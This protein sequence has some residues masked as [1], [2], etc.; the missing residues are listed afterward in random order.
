MIKKLAI[1]DLSSFIF[2]AFFGIRSL[3]APDGTPTNAVFGVYKMLFKLLREHQPTHI[4]LARDSKGKTF[5]HEIFEDYKANRGEPPED[6]IPQFELI[7]KLVEKMHLRFCMHKGVEA[8]DII[9]SAVTQWKDYFDEIFI[10]SSDKDLMQF[11]DDEKVFMVDT[12]KDKKMGSKE[13]V[14]KLGV[15]P[16]QVVDY[17]TMLGDTSDNIPGMRG[18]GK[19]KAAKLLTEYGTFENCIKQKDKFTGKVLVTAFKDYLEDGRLSKQLVKIKTDVHLGVTPSQTKYEFFPDDELIQYLK[20]DLGFKGASKQLEDL[21][22]DIQKSDNQDIKDVQKAFEY[23]LIDNQKNF[24]ATLDLLQRNHILSIHVHYENQLAF[25]SAI[26]FVSISIDG[27]QAYIFAFC[28]KGMNLSQDNLK[29]LLKTCMEKKDKEIIGSNLKRD[30][31]YLSLH[32]MSLK[33]RIFDNIVAHYILNPDQGHD[34]GR[35]CSIYL[36]YTPLTIDKK[37]LSLEQWDY[38]KVA[39]YMGERACCN[40]LL[41]KRLK[42]ELSLHELQDVYD[43]M[44]GPMISVLGDLEVAGILIDRD[45]FKELDRNFSH[46]LVQIEKQVK[47]ELENS[48]GEDTPP[49][50]LRSPKQVGKLLFED[51]K[52]P[53]IKKTKT[54]YSTDSSVLEALEGLQKSEIPG[55]ILKFREI[56]KL[57]STYVKALPELVNQKTLRLHTTFLLYGAATGR[58]YSVNPN[59]QNIPVRSSNGI[60]IRQGFVAPAD[61]YLLSADYSQVELRLLA[62]FSKDPTMVKAFRNNTD[63]HTQTASEILNIPIA[64]VQ[65]DQRSMAK[66]VNFGLIY[67]QSSFGLSQQLKISRKEA[68]EYIQ[69][70]FE[71]FGKIRCYLDELKQSAEEIGY[72]KTLFGRKR[73]LPDI[74]SQNR[75]I[76]SAAERVAVNSPIQGTAADIIKLAMIEIH[77]L[78]EKKGLRAKMLLQVHD[79]LIFEVPESELEQVKSLVKETMENIVSLEVPLKVDLG[80]GKNWLELK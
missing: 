61:H 12:M 58:L 27:N 16:D 26:S 43:N 54:G 36:D 31:R 49:V 62:H 75:M 10:V 59:L 34:F 39:K 56:D 79:E 17:L 6:L 47:K 51:L 7:E 13:V 3:N 63:I 70:Y 68:K 32:K 41:A 11:L 64:D 74:K 35:L 42:D 37:D 53:V 80:V 46:Q 50:N 77:H 21:L 40:F 44:D 18:I 73:F 67:G 25:D 9:G 24:Q 29:T 48:I 28:G 20:N 14:K 65:R 23:V 22:F 1:V 57:L 5:R 45:F 55:F 30:Y 19:V 72:S 33:G 69:R 78:L 2:R 52:F 60:K 66:A 38:S 15:R 8:D 76:K 4:F 71:K